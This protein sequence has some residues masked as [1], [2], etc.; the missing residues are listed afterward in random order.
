MINSLK[1]H[2]AALCSVLTN[3]LIRFYPLC[4]LFFSVKDSLYDF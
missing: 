2:D 3:E 1:R 4:I